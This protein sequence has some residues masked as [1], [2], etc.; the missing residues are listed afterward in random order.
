MFRLEHSVRTNED[1]D[2][3]RLQQIA[4]MNP[5]TCISNP[6]ILNE[7]KQLARET[8]TSINTL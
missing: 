2:F 3:Q 5:S 4:R 8:S 1:L 6:Y 7:F